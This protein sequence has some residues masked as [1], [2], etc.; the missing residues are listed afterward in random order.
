MQGAW[1]LDDYTYVE[2]DDIQLLCNP[3]SPTST[4]VIFDY[5]T[6]MK[7]SR[8]SKESRWRWNL[9]E[10]WLLFRARFQTKSTL[11]FII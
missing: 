6:R 1:K 11:V 10:N 2:F 9:H 3:F 7:A 5:L 4:C 8:Q